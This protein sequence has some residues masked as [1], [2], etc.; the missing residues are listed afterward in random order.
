MLL[1]FARRDSMLKRLWMS[2]GTTFLSIVRSRT[3]LSS[4]HFPF[5]RHSFCREQPEKGRCPAGRSAFHGGF[6]SAAS[7]TSLGIFIYVEKSK[8]SL[9]SFMTDFHGLIRCNVTGMTSS[10][11]NTECFIYS[12]L[13]V[14]VNFYTE[15]K[16]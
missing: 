9:K 1:N 2:I 16:P 10:E 8:F 5:K 13:R 3:S 11:H 15:C 14:N 4:S 12:Y 6:A 7:R